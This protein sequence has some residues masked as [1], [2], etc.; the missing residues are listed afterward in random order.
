MPLVALPSWLPAQS[1]YS[2]ASQESVE[3]VL[4]MMPYGSCSRY[5]WF[6]NPTPSQVET[7]ILGTIIQG[8]TNDD[9]DEP[10]Q[11]AT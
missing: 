5:L 4:P 2:G 11:L 7:D 1:A 3:S 9:P 6:G 10:A 8:V